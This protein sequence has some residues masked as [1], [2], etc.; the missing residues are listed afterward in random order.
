[1]SEATHSSQPVFG[2]D[3]RDG[4]SLQRAFVGATAPYVERLSGLETLQRCY[5][6][7]SRPGM[8]ARAFIDS[9]LETLGVEI[10]CSAA[11]R[12]RI[13][14][15]GPFVVVSN[16]P[17][18]AL[19]GLLLAKLL[20]E[21]RS[22]V[23]IL[24]NYILERIPELRDTFLF[25]DPW[26]RASSRARNARALKEMV[27][28]L[29]RGGLLA[30]FPGGEVAHRSFSDGGE[31]RD[32]PW[33]TSVGKLIQRC[34]APVLP[35][36]FCG[37]N[38]LGF[39]LAGMVHPLF[40]TALLPRE[41]LNKRGRQVRVRIG[42]PIRTSKLKDEDP[43]A[44][45]AYL[46]ERT[47]ILKYRSERTEA[48]RSLEPKPV[49]GPVAT[50]VLS[51]EV[52]SLSAERCLV[53]HEGRRVFMAPASE[54][55]Y[56]L[57]ELGRLRQIAFREVG[58]GTDESRDLDLF[59]YHYEHL[60]VWDDRDQQIVGAYRIGLVDRI[61][62]E[63]GKQGLYISTL[64]DI[65]DAF[66]ERIGA[67]LELGRSFVQPR[68]Q[69]DSTSLFLLWKGIGV[70]VNRHP[71]YRYLFGPCSVSDDYEPM[72][73][74]LIVRYLD[75]EHGAP[76]LSRYLH[77]RLPLRRAPR[78]DAA[79]PRYDRWMTSMGELSNWITH[80][81]SD[82]KRVPVLVRQY[83]RLGGKIL[84]F[85]VDPAFGSVV[86]CFVLVDL[87]EAPLR[88]LSM[89]MGADQTR[90]FRKALSDRAAALGQTLPGQQPGK[91]PSRPSQ[92]SL[93]ASA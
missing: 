33:Q 93:S 16:H 80:L 56:V 28:H 67:A 65:E 50:H 43:A 3:R 69:R 20:L 35:V 18:G 76:E 26:A 51:R 29:R 13:P 4:P 55:P 49:A 81:E 11:E 54:I 1:M 14:E 21:R 63:R 22:D 64:F 31:L 78:V 6:R 2:L 60:F 40:R 42:Q 5:E 15:K 74:H 24:A 73:R 59:D 85:N 70:F 9:A 68:Y 71:E 46:Q 48:P 19:E 32:P 77:P 57:L 25:V 45:T 83:I 39:Q 90:A 30:V 27:G 37:E 62:A 92:P 36:Y 23:R 84:G 75:R 79:L 86:D 10:D 44:F 66:F 41:L 82:E 47:E 58:E 38:S 88:V 72:S 52:D 87:A 8:D 53:S 91:R 34:G 61:V 7:A 12:M 17:F 89:F